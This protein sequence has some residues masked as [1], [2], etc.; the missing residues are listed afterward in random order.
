M[1]T[2]TAKFTKKKKEKRK[3]KKKATD[4]QNSRTNGKSKA[5]QTK[6]HTE[7]YGN[8][9]SKKGKKYIYIVAPKIHLLYLG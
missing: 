7:A 5:I 2:N 8:T 4:S 9:K 6:S 3:K 1:K